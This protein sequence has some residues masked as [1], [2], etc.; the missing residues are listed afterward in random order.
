MLQPWAVGSMSSVKGAQLYQ[1]VL[2]ADHEFLVQHNIV[3]LI[4]SKE[5]PYCGE[6]HP[7]RTPPPDVPTKGRGWDRRVF[8]QNGMRIVDQWDSV[9]E[10][11]RRTYEPLTG[12]S[13]SSSSSS[14]FA[15][16]TVDWLL[17][18]DCRILVV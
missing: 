14:G 4:P 6:N 9:S 8:E 2:K 18:R 3:Q 10:Q 7:P 5:R 13:S 17:C 12:G 1:P 15:I 16:L 11:W